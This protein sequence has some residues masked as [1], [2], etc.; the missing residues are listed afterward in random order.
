VRARVDP[1]WDAVLGLAWEAFLRRTTPVG[2]VVVDPLGRLDAGA[3]GRRLDSE[4]TPGQLSGTRIAHA[5]L[6]A[7]ALLPTRGSY[8]SARNPSWLTS[9]ADPLAS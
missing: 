3:R 5:E 9:H 2:A 6:N 1:P 4:Q 8:G 7:L